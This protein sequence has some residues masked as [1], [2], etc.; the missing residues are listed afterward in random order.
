MVAVGSSGKQEGGLLVD[1]GKQGS[2]DH[3]PHTFGVDTTI[4][5]II[6]QFI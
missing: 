6:N 2:R 1:W 3:T 4:L 5:V